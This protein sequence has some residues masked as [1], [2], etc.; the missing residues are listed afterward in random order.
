MSIIEL[1][2]LGFLAEKPMCGYTLRKKMEQLQGSTRTFS[3]GAIY[4]ATKRLVDAGMISQRDETMDG[5]QRRQFTLEEPGENR[6][7]EALAEA[8][9]FYISDT[10]KWNVVLT[11]LSFL[12]SATRRNA[13]LRRRYD[14]LVS[15]D[16]HYFYCDSGRALEASEI[17]DPY[18]QGIIAVHEAA[19]AAEL[20]WLRSVLGIAQLAGATRS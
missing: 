7:A 2:I 9:G 19:L 15:S 18:R 1:M 14:Y 20:A 11:F 6:L 3:D 16:V 8:D 17:K 13:V 12:D 5:R 10:G 4:P